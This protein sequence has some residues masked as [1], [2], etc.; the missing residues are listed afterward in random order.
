MYALYSAISTVVVV[1]FLLCAGAVHGQAVQVNR[2]APTARGLSNWWKTVPGL[3]GAG[4]LY[5]LMGGPPLVLTNMAAAGTSGW[6]PTARQGGAAEMRFDGV[7]DLLATPANSSQMPP[8]FTIMMWLKLTGAFAGDYSLLWESV[9]GHGNIFGRST[10]QLSTF[11]DSATIDGPAPTVLAQQTWYHVAMVVNSNELILYLNCQIEASTAMPGPFP[12][13]A[14]SHQLGA[15]PTPA[16]LF[17]G[18]MDD[19]RFYTRVISQAELCTVMRESLRGD[20]VLLPRPDPIAAVAQALVI[21]KDRFFPFF[22]PRGIAVVRA[23]LL[24]LCMV[25]VGAVGEARN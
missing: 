19:I 6:A 20:P 3:A 1:V 23:C 24:L 11:T 22:Q 8:Y 7:D 10:G 25:S 18:V 15:R 9:G 14:M 17:T 12:P 16:T 4:R 5:D 13:G 21:R 2:S